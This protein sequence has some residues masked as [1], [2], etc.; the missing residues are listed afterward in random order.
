MLHPSMCSCYLIERLKRV[1]L[2]CQWPLSIPIASASVSEGLSARRSPFA[3]QSS[4]VFL[5]AA[6][7]SPARTSDRREQPTFVSLRSAKVPFLAVLCSVILR[8]PFFKRDFRILSTHESMS[9][10]ASS[11]KVLFSFLRKSTEFRLCGS[12]S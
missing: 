3:D 5:W 6:V 12:C 4:H 9:F 2:Y 11:R 10:F 1:S 8:T 7:L